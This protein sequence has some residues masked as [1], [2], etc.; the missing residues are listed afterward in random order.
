VL[1]LNKDRESNTLYTD[2]VANEDFLESHVLHIPAP[3][4]GTSKEVGNIREN[5]TKARQ[6]STFNGKTVVIK[7]SFVYSNKGGFAYRE[8]KALADGF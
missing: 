6:F 2:L 1:L 4:S 5:R 3:G 7:E 8:S